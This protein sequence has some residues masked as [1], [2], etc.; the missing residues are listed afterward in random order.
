MIKHLVV[1]LLIIFSA[2]AASNAVPVYFL[3]GQFEIVDNTIS[4]GG[5]LGS[6]STKITN[7]VVATGTNSLGV[8]YVNQNT[9]DRVYT[10]SGYGY[11]MLSQTSDVG[12]SS[13]SQLVPGFVSNQ[14]YSVN[15]FTTCD[16]SQN[17][18]PPRQISVT[19]TYNS[20]GNTLL[21][22]PVYA[23]CITMNDSVLLWQKSYW[24]STYL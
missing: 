2:Y 3:N 1:S 20:T 11:V 21:N 13:I 16:P 24:I 9:T 19:I 7:W 15:F 8:T 14:Y 12:G 22:Q 4:T 10:S 17:G 6:G 23:P 18:S 5:L